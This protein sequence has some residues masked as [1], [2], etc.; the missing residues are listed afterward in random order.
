MGMRQ[1]EEAQKQSTYEWRS[2]SFD[3][4]RP[5]LRSPDG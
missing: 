2:K 4:T 5:Q 3:V 1:R